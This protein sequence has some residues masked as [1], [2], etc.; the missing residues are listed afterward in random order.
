MET[1]RTE[2][3][4]RSKNSFDFDNLNSDE[5]LTQERLNE[6]FILNAEYDRQDELFSS[7]KEKLEADLMTAPL[8]VEKAYSY[9]GLL[10]GTFPPAAFF[11]KF[12]FEAGSPGNNEF[13]IIFLLTIVN[14]VTAAAGYFS[15][16]LIG[17]ITF[18]LEKFSWHRMLLALP[19]LGFLWGIISGGAGGFFIFVFGAIFGAMIGGLVGSVALPAFTIFHR[20]LKRGDKIENKHFLP[21]AFGI[22]IIISTYI[23]GF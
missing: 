7:D 10:L 21:I 19:F 14:I 13:W 18:E 16:K 12:F 2:T 17:K 3:K 4:Y 23:L 20:L 9:F 6:L 8:S 15:G 11:A 22:T 5:Q 1:T